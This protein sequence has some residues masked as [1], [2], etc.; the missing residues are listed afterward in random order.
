MCIRGSRS[1]SGHP[2][3]SV[4]ADLILAKSRVAQ[5]PPSRFPSRLSSTLLFCRLLFYSSVGIGIGKTFLWKEVKCGGWAC[6]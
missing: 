1:S 3:L 2:V 5:V 6:L 4:L